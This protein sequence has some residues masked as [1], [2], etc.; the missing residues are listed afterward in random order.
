MKSSHN[1]Q[2]NLLPDED[3]LIP[4]GSFLRSISLDELPELFNAIKEDMILVG[5]PVP[6]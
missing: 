2:G 4:F 3:R 5:L 6:C 1:A